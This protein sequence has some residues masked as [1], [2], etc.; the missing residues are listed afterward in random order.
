MSR[1]LVLAVCASSI[2]FT[3]HKAARGPH[4]RGLAESME[5]EARNCIQASTVTWQQVNNVKTICVL[6]DYEASRAHGRQAWIDIG[7]PSQTP[8]QFPHLHYVDGNVDIHS[9]GS[10]PS[11]ASQIRQRT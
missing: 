11:A 6:I 4:A 7:K 8:G 3:V 1:A 9:N 5:R 10:Q 2:R